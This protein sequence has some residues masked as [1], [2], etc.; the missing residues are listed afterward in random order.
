MSIKR[1]LFIDDDHV[2]GIVD[3]LRKNLKKNGVTLS[4]SVLH[5]NQDKFKMKNDEGKIILDFEKIKTDLR[6][7]HMS[8]LYDV[9]SCD[10]YFAKDPLDGYQI[11]KWLKNESESQKKKIRRAKYFLYSSEGDKMAK[12]LNSVNDIS[13]LIKLKL[14]D[15]F[16]RENLSIDL[17]KVILNSQASFS[18]S[19]KLLNE[20]DKYPGCEFKSVYPK[21]KGKKLHEIAEEIDK[22]LPNGVDFQ[23]NLAELTIAHMIELNNFGTND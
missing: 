18:F 10:Y 4:E 6:D 17:T 20:F 7:N 14:T 15:F 3:K 5:L 21:F 8:E 11:L 1:I 23:N 22:E 16:K 12:D 2:D 9:V 19:D 13:Q